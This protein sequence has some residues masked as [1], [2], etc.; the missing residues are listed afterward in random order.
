MARYRIFLTTSPLNTLIVSSYASSTKRDEDKDVLILDFL[1]QKE[2]SVFQIKKLASIHDYNQI[3]DF[4]IP[5]ADTSVS[6][7]GIIKK[8]TRYFKRQP[9][10]KQ[11][12]DLL[13]W[14]RYRKDVRKFKGML[15]A[16]NILNES[17]QYS[18]EI[19]TQPL[20]R[21][22]DPLIELF[23][24]ANVNYFEHGI[25]DYFDIIDSKKSRRFFPLLE[26]AF[27]N[28]LESNGIDSI[29]IEPLAID[30]RNFR[31]I[32]T[33]LFPE[34]SSLNKYQNVVLIVTQPLEDFSV[35]ASFWSHFLEGVL[36]KVGQAE[37]WNYLIKMHPRQNVESIEAITSFLKE[38]N[39]E[40]NV[41][42][43]NG[44]NNL[45]LE[46][47]FGALMS[48]TRYVFTPF[49]S[50]IFYL[51]VLYPDAD[52]AYYYSIKSLRDYS[53]LT[54]S[55]YKARWRRIEE[56]LKFTKSNSVKEL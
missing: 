12:Y 19:N 11:V 9:G 2:S 42:Q 35:S 18:V 28:Y 3:H 30:F 26:S 8:L 13:Y 41:I 36:A 46:F 40:F 53:S 38:R 15:I 48:H 43:D 6:N 39:V 54:A 52:I 5:L 56:L 14:F 31:H 22:H 34:I 24:T 1:A 29:K 55:Q 45:A 10:F 49:S 33:N 27:R 4:T 21:F 47:L 23:P 32:V 44:L 25:G 7:P 17:S 37:R 16:K 51:P 50:A 20:L